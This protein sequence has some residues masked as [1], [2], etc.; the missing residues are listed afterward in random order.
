VGS[1]LFGTVHIPDVNEGYENLLRFLRTA[2]EL[3]FHRS[4]V[5]LH[6]HASSESE[7]GGILRVHHF[8]A[9]TVSCSQDEEIVYI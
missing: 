9:S 7:S 5:A 8:T 3:K 2:K 4:Y 1:C 6:V